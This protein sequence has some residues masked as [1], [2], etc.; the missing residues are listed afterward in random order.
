MSR[1]S[2]LPPIRGT[3]DRGSRWSRDADGGDT[4]DMHGRKEGGKRG[5]WKSS[6]LNLSSESSDNH[7]SNSSSSDSEVMAIKVRTGGSRAGRGR[8]K[9]L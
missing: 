7:G 4:G 8:S 2:R 9:L 3:G 6:A 5:V 1:V